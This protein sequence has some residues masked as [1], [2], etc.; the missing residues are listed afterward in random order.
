MRS[1]C[2]AGVEDIISKD[3]LGVKELDDLLDVFMPDATVEQPQS[4]S[5][6][7][8]EEDI[9]LFEDEENVLARYQALFARVSRLDPVVEISSS[10][11]GA[12]K[13]QLLYYLTATAVLPLT[14]EGTCTGG[15]D[16]AVVFIDADCRF[17]ADRLRT[18]ARGILQERLRE[19]PGGI[20]PSDIECI[21]LASL[22]HVH[23]FRPQSSSS[24]LATLHNLDT[25]LFDLSRHLSSNRPLQAIIIDS[26]SA[27]FWQDRLRDE[28]SRTEEIGRPLADLE[29]DREQ[30][31]S[32]YQ[33]DLYA[34]LVKEL[35]RLQL[36]FSCAV[37]Y[38]TMTWTGKSSASLHAQSHRPSGPFD[39]YNPP[40]FSKT[41]A[42]RPSLP[43]PWGTFPTLRLLVQRDSVRPFPPSMTARDA[44]Q[45]AAM[46]HEVVRQGKFSGWVNGWGQEE[47]PRRVVDG[48]E[49]LNGGMFVFYAR[50]QGVEIPR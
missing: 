24:L 8:T 14:Y 48:V 29:R 28:I 44:E 18:V 36:R 40:V 6:L 33:A 50:G 10:S 13:S 38:S 22:Q 46:R 30:K 26:A 15:R 16:S 21:L 9:L 39:L 34:E 23:V 41:P 2:R 42:L 31:Q 35:K 20:K 49:R 17:D 32:F 1:L 4:L 3:R 7:Q 5:H 37:I 47:W 25:Y 27:F 12:G 19:Q 43:A 45:D 11:S